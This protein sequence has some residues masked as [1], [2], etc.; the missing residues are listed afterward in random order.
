MIQTS[1]LTNAAY[2]QIEIEEWDQ[3]AAAWHK[4]IPIINAFVSVATDIML[5]QAGVETGNQV[6][7]ITA[8]DGSQSIMAAERVG[9]TG[10]VLATD[11]SP[12]FVK[13]AR[14]IARTQGVTNM[15]AEVMDAENLALQDN[16]FDAA[17][18]RLG[19]MFLPDP[20]R[21]VQE[22]HRV[23]KPA[24]AFAA[25]VYTTPDKT[26]F[27]TQSPQ[28][29]RE[30]LN[31]PE[32]PTK[33]APTHTSPAPQAH[34][35]GPFALGTPDFFADLFAQAGFVNIEQE[36]IEAPLRFDT[37]EDFIQWR[38]DVAIS[39]KTMLAGQDTETQERIWQEITKAM[40]QYE[41]SDGFETPT[42]LLICSGQKPGNS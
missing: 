16:S 33:E 35:P 29:I 20:L 5:D 32:P 11:I 7:D 36:I 1:N 28:I 19:M 6:L 40:R 13:L 9:K 2:K 23:L 24:G 4:W 39:H 22:I 42:E 3:A 26:P 27:F 15:T 12:A 25:I 37:T 21:G 14:H 17:I 30:Q 31:L 8:G 38:R 10:S 41:T 34:Q 18:S